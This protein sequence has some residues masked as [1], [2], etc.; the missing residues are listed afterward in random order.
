VALTDPRALAEWL[1]PNDFSPVVGHKF[2]FQ[3]DPMPGCGH[4]LTEC[5]VLE[6][7]PP[8]RLVYSWSGHFKKGRPQLGRT[9]VTWTLT[10]EGEGTRLVLVQSG[11]ENIPFIPRQMMRFGWGTMV[12]RFI[13]KVLARV[14]TDGVFSPGA[15]PLEK[16]CY[17]CR[18]IPEHLVR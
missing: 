11:L 8:R 4:G 2:R 18:T 10:P 12:K 5:E 15:F 6:V 7:D 17:K 14:S 13:P 9:I 1:M 3:V 16:R